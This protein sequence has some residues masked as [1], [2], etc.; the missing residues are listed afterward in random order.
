MEGMWLKEALCG[1]MSAA[2]V[3][4]GIVLTR[5]WFWVRVSGCALLYRGNTIDAVDLKQILAVANSG[6][7]YIE[8]P[9]YIEHESDS[10]YVYTVRCA[11][12]CG[13][14]EDTHAAV[15]KFS[16][17]GNG[18]LLQPCPNRVCRLGGRQVSGEKVELTWFYEP[19]GQG[20]V[21]ARFNV[22]SNGG[23]G[24]IDFDTPIGQIAYA[25]RRL[26]SFERDI[27]SAAELWFGVKAQDGGGS[28][29]AA[30]RVRVQIDW[31]SYEAAEVLNVE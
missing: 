19:L 22:Y 11:N 10:T 14:L 12:H 20:A 2:G 7:A 16:T 23:T 27:G 29:G 30:A 28:Q 6:S 18:E 13:E 17:D 9:Q 25:G 4:L 8:P 31:R 24:E 3:R 26:Y 15:V 1:G 21:P 5:G